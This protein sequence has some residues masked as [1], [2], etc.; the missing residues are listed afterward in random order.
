[1][2]HDF[3]LPGEF[4]M[5]FKAEYKRLRDQHPNAPAQFEEVITGVYTSVLQ[6]NDISVDCGAHTGKHTL[7]M[8]RRIG[9]GGRVF[10]FE[11]IAEKLAVLESKAKSAE[12]SEVI[13]AR[14]C[15]VGD[16]RGPIS[17]NFVQAD[18]GKSSLRLR[19]DLRSD[20]KKM[21]TN[22]VRQLEMVRLDD[23]IPENGRC[24]FIKV[25][26]EGAELLVLKGAERTIVHHRP[27]VH[28]ELGMICLKEFG[29]SPEELWAF[30]SDKN[31]TLVDVVGNVLE[32]E[33]EFLASEAASGL[34]DYF[35]VPHDIETDLIER[36][37]SRVF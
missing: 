28:F 9:P 22:L 23:C 7:P 20:A 25:D 31:Y 14:N 5:D 33:S 19:Q 26:V 18:P 36:A 15:V 32:T 35:A 6:P 34:Y 27:I 2:N 8:A 10:A 4:G 16:K 29:A 24:R 17:F 11:P 30:F 3:T 21:E 13:T 12:L 1:L 37:A